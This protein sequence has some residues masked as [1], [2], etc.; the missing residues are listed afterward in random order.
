MKQI[1]SII[2]RGL[3]NPRHFIEALGL[4]RR[5][6]RLIATTAILMM[7]VASFL[8]I[9]SPL[10]HVVEDITGAAAYIPNYTV[11]NGELT[12][13]APDKPVYYQ[14]DYAQFVI[15][16]TVASTG[17]SKTLLLPDNKATM[18]DPYAVVGLYVFKDQA[19]LMLNETLYVFEDI[20]NGSISH[21]ALAD[22][23]RSFEQM[24]LPILLTGFLTTLVLSALGYLIQML[25]ITSMVSGFNSRLTQPIPFK[26]RLRLTMT[27]SLFPLIVLQGFPLP[28]TLQF[29]LLMSITLFIIYL[30]FKKHTD[31][32]R[33]IMNG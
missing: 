31:F 23:A 26:D 18:I 10:L 24:K 12:I 20:H 22:Y 2:S 3:R 7:S 6:L 33:N 27:V 16:D 14:S 13:Q 21:E 30:M 17:L 32:I 29:F 8:N 25:I 19:L 4:K 28:I 11:S 15:D 1:I 5:Q 9:L